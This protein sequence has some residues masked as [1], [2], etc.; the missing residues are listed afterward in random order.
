M[1]VGVWHGAVYPPLKINRNRGTSERSARL[2][3][4]ILTGN[5]MEERRRRWPTAKQA[6]IIHLQDVCHSQHSLHP[7]IVL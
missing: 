5:R 3:P 6:I 4:A 7:Q 2:Q 1:P